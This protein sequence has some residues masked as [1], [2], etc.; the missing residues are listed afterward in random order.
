VLNDINFNDT[1]LSQAHLEASFPTRQFRYLTKGEIARPFKITFPD[2]PEVGVGRDARFFA[3]F[4]VCIAVVVVF[5]VASFNISRRFS[6]AE[7]C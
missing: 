1:F 7:H 3:F 4:F 6:F 5:A 2:N